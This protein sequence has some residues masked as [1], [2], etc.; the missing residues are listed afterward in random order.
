MT[1]ILLFRFIIAA[2]LIFILTLAVL[3][4]PSGKRIELTQFANSK[5][6]GYA[7]IEPDLK[8][9]FMKNWIQNRFSKYWGKPE[10]TLSNYL[11][12]AIKLFQVIQTLSVA[13]ITPYYAGVLFYSVDEAENPLMVYVINSRI[14]QSIFKFIRLPISLFP[15]NFPVKTELFKDEIEINHKKHKVF[16][17]GRYF[18]FYQQNLIFISDIRK[19][20]KYALSDTGKPIPGNLPR[21]RS[22]LNPKSDFMLIFDNRLK[23][24]RLI[25]R[26]LEQKKS[27]FDTELEREFFKTILQRLKIYSDSIIGT[28]IQADIKDDDLIKGKWLVIMNSEQSARKIAIVIDGL[29]QVISKELS[30]QELLYSVKRAIDYNQIISEFEIKGLRKLTRPY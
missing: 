8:S 7:Q 13:K 27:L 2:L 14:H 12:P 16:R 17:Y 26:Y 18:L 20:F 29:H 21:I 24:G 3:I 23:T 4:L 11:K 19:A 5:L 10:D 30:N 22:L 28:A 25:Q 1:L 9:Q 6:L 15:T